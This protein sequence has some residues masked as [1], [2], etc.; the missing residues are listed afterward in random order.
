MITF[1]KLIVVEG[2][3]GAGKT[4]AIKVINEWLE[5]RLATE[6]VL[7]REPGGTALGESIRTLLKTCNTEEPID[8]LSE[9]LLVYASRVQHVN[10]VIKPALA[11]GKWVVCDRFE[12]STFAY[13][14]GGRA[15]NPE[16]ISSL[17]N[18]C[19]NQFQAD[20]TL[21]LDIKPD[22]GLIRAQ[23]RGQFDRFEQEPIDFFNA[24][25]VAYH[26]QIVNK[27][28]IKII[29]AN[30]TLE[31]VKLDLILHLQQFLT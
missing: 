26:Q 22:L 24:I 15:I 14:G 6:I 23:K 7:T 29:D 30:Q 31:N 28:N 10:Q 4:T 9:L 5:S 16:V 3:E 20:L 27:A 25:Y 11:A 13:Q 1:G 19:L 8:S 21:F 17:S 12:L 2:L 18:L